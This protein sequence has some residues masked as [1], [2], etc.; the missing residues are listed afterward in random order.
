MRVQYHLD[1]PYEHIAPSFFQEF[2]HQEILRMIGILRTNGMKLEPSVYNCSGSPGVALYPIY[3]LINHAC[4]NNTNYVK[5]PDLHLEL[6][7]Q[8]PI[9]K[10]QEIFTRYISST[11]GNVRRR[12]DIRRYWF[13]DCECDRC[14]DPTEMGTLMSALR[15]LSCDSGFLLPVDGLDYESDWAC[16]GCSKT[17]KFKTVDEVLATIEKQV[18]NVISRRKKLSYSLMLY[19][20]RSATLTLPR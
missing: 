8:L 20:F 2:S 10:G 18:R 19:F 14:R 17:V 9:R 12:Q 5:F 4:Y 16:D 1:S 15:C 11:I 3:C 6:R 13:F 7:S